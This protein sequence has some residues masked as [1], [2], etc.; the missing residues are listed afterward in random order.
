MTDGLIGKMGKAINLVLKNDQFLLINN[1]DEWAI[2]HKFAEYIQ[3]QF[4]EF[5]VDVEYNREKDQ[6]K[7][8]NGER[9]RPD[10]IV[11]IRNTDVNLIAIE[12]KKSNNIGEMDEVR[13]RLKNLTDSNGKFQYQLGLFAVF[14]VKDEASKYPFLE[15]YQNGAKFEA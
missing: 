14:Y 5:H 2:S 12:V 13:E 8:L 4:P 6:V 9:I 15:Y 3:Q 11:H 1:S 7:T 10:I